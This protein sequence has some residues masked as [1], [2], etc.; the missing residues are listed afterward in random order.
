MS[1]IS[2]MNGA[3]GTAHA[4]N[5]AVVAEGV[6]PASHVNGNP[7]QPVVIGASQQPLQPLKIGAYSVS[8]YEPGSL[9][10]GAF[11][12]R[13]EITSGFS[14]RAIS[15]LCRIKAAWVSTVSMVTFDP[16]SDKGWHWRDAADLAKRVL[17]DRRSNSQSK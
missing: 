3:A 9:D 12:Q 7:S 17:A 1:A 10:R 11:K 16:F 14:L 4:T 6:R 2:G 13:A 15:F 8:S 5:G